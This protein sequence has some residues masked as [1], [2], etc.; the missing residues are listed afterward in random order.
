MEQILYDVVRVDLVPASDCDLAVPYQRTVTKT[1]ATKT[2]NG[3]TVSRIGAALLSV[4]FNVQDGDDGLMEDSP[5]L[6]QTPKTEKAGLIVTHTLEVP[7][8]GGFETTAIA[9]KLLHRRDF[10]VVLTTDSGERYLLYSLP[11]SSECLLKGQGV[12][13]ES[14]LNVTLRSASHVIRLT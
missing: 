12:K 6:V 11:G 8:F 13:T 10:H 1:P 7:V 3:E 5:K 2:V 4:A 9:A 14:T